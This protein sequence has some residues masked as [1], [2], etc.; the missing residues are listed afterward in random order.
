MF[1]KSLLMQ[2]ALTSHELLL[3]AEVLASVS[4]VQH[5]HGV[6]VGLP[7]VLRRLDG[8]AEPE[9]HVGHGHDDDAV[10]G[11]GV[12][13]DAGEGGLGHGV[14]E[15]EGALGVGLE[16]DAAAG[17][18]GEEVE[19]VDGEVEGAAVGEIDVRGVTNNFLAFGITLSLLKRHNT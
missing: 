14:A 7:A 18:G 15:E 10:V 19:R 13:G 1:I 8:D 2:S 16:P 3:P 9:G 5:N 17:V 6:G 11:L 4:L 12:L